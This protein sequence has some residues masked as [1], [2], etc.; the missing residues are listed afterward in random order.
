MIVQFLNWQSVLL[1]S[2]VDGEMPVRGRENIW[3]INPE[4][5]SQRLQDQ[6]KY[7]DYIPIE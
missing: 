3:K 7:L 4:K 6:S 2:K 5:F 1:T